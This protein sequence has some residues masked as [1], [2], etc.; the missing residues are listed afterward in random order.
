MA[1]D[2]KGPTSALAGNGVQAEGPEV[3]GCSPSPLADIKGAGMR[4]TGY[5]W[6]RPDGM[7][8]HDAAFGPYVAGKTLTVPGAAAGD[9]CG[10]GLHF[11]ERI[12]DAVGYG[13]FPGALWR[14]ESDGPVLGRDTTKMRVASLLVVEAV[15][16]PAW[17]VAV[18]DF[19]ATIPTVPW[20]TPTGPPDPAWRHYSARASAW[21][22]ARDSARDSVWDSAR[23]SA[24][25]SA[26]AS[27]GAS[28]GLM[29]AML[30]V[31]D[32]E[33]V[34]LAHRDHA[35]ARWRVWM[36]G[37]GLACDV[38]GVLYTYDRP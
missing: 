20:F 1:T 29:A 19:I 14:V 13:R 35:A 34:P 27:A 11:S 25:D 6:T 3:P 17:V 12:E 30:C 7:S 31:C 23:A 36:M 33:D 10:V 22:S 38:N 32:R 4:L 28:A 5:K 8:W 15:E 18:E 16:K 9:A 24:W 2:E 21:D 37:Y 26:W